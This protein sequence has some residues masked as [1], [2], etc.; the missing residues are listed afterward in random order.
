MPYFKICCKTMEYQVEHRCKD[1]PG[2]CPDQVIMVS[3]S[4]TKLYL[5]S[6]N[7]EYSFKYCPWCGSKVNF[8]K[9]KK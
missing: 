1:H 7:A 3:H 6:A 4:G 5:A 9:D 8:K 2:Y